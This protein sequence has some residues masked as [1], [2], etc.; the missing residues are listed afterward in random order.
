MPSSGSVAALVF[1][2]VAFDRI[3]WRVVGLIACGSL[4][5][6]F[7]GLVAVAYGVSQAIILTGG[8]EQAG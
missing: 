7:L 2:L 3:D 1:V 4:V 6:G 5:G 8:A